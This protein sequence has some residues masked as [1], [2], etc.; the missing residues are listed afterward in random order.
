MYQECLSPFHFRTAKLTIPVNMFMHSHEIT[1]QATVWL[2]YRG[3]ARYSA[4]VCATARALAIFP[5][6]QLVWFITAGTFICLIWIVSQYDRFRLF[7]SA[8]NIK[9]FGCVFSNMW[10]LFHTSL[11]FRLYYG[12][13]I[14]YLVKKIK[15]FLFNW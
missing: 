2:V 1:H 4:L 5:T 13:E 12:N 7:S 8:I 3:V 9:H 11:V 15:L 6:P 10:Y 14:I